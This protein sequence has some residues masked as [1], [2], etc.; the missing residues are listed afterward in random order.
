VPNIGNPSFEREP[1]YRN[2]KLP[3]PGYQLLALY[4]FWNIIEYWFPYRDL[5]GENWDGVLMTFIP[6]IT[7]A[8]D[9]E[10]YKRELMALIARVHDTHANLWSSLD[11]RPPVGPC[12]GSP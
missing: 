12:A 1:A 4:R 11:V 5:I 2:I 6:R 8:R 9:G 7:L 10:T 3:D